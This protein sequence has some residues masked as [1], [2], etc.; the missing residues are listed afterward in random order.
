[1]DE[2]STQIL[3]VLNNPTN[4]ELIEMLSSR[5]LTPSEI[6]RE[7]KKNETMVVRKLR[8]MENLGIL[9]SHWIGKRK[10]Y[11]LK[12]L[13]IKIGEEIVIETKTPKLKFACASTKQNLAL[14]LIYG[15]LVGVFL[16]EG[17][18]LLRIFVL[19]FLAWHSFSYLA[20]HRLFGDKGHLYNGLVFLV[21]VLFAGFLLFGSEP[22]TIMLLGFIFLL[23][24]LMAYSIFYSKD[25]LLHDEEIKKMPFSIKLITFPYFLFVMLEEYWE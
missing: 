4:R 9:N 5:E 23:G 17:D 21:S 18:S 16:V 7:T 11:N 10:Y 15:A 6:V 22:P 14:Y 1:M 12:E 8:E 19:F 3:K 25:M 20:L 24:F 13:Q 2:R